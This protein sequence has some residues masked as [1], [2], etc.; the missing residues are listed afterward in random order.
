MPTVASVLADYRTLNETDQEKVRSKIRASM[1]TGTNLKV[2][3]EGKRFAYG[4]VCPHCGSTH[5]VRNGKR[6]DGTQRYKCMDCGKRFVISTNS[7]VSGTRKGLSVWVEFIECMLLGLSLEDCA[8]KCGIHKNTA[9]AL[10]HKVL[11]ALQK[12]AESV[13][14][15]GI[16]EADETFFPLSYK[17][18]SK[19]LKAPIVKKR[20]LSNNQICVPCAVN[21]SG[22]SIAKVANR[23]RV[24]EKG[25][26]AVLGGRIAS[27][28]NI[29][30]DGATTYRKFAAKNGLVLHQLTGGKSTTSGIYSINH[31]NSYHS[32]LKK[33]MGTFRGV[34]T[35]YLNNYLVWFNYAKYKRVSLADK[36]EKMLTYIFTAVFYERN[37]DIGKRDDLP[38]LAKHHWPNGQWCFAILFCTF[39]SIL[40]L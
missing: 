5:V 1:S 31:I 40:C 24:K 32:Q 12:L 38:I 7:V 15:D 14:L 2:Y 26:D 27:G 10:R 39:S 6:P 17:G 29:V 4:R 33:F 21:R 36:Q 8:D 20:G 35:K 28:S 18:N 22:M 19:G 16:V 30:T 34:V 11:D 3:M 13:N 23:A 37:C 25:L 9:F